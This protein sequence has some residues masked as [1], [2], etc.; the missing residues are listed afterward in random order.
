MVFMPVGEDDAE[1]VLLAILY[2]FEIG[3]DDVDARIIMGTEGHAK[4]EHD[5]FAVA[6][7]EIGVHADLARPAERDEEQFL[8]GNGHAPVPRWL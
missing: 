2:E 6:A 5:P 3:H 7:I 1:Q 4:V 8:A